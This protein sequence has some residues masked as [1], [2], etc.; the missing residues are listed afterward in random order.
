MET[1]H[2]AEF[3]EFLKEI[4]KVGDITQYRYGLAVK[5]LDPSKLSQEYINQYI[6]KKGND[7]VIRGA[8][9]SFFEMTGLHRMFD[10]PPKAT[11]RK[12]KR[13]IR[14][15]S[16]DDINKVR[17]YLY[18]DDFKEGLIFDLIYQGALRRAEVPP[19]RINSFKWLKFLD[20]TSKPC[21]LVVCGKGDKER[22]VLINSGTAEKIFN[23][24]HTK[25]QFSDMEMV[26]AFANSVSLL[27]MKDDKPF[28]N[29]MVWKVVNKGSTKS[30]GRN[31]RTH[32]LRHARA[33][34][35]VNMGVPIKDIQHYLG[36]TSIA[37]TEVYLHRSEK[38]SLA[39]IEKIQEINQ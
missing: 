24:Y 9:L 21:H 13:E 34:E 11:G 4:K 32:E 33:T 39:N 36:H 31:I 17:D 8:M 14:D 28:S 37:T 15:V 30:I 12:R 25:Y 18:K 26:T 35:L 2:L 10:L 19:I 7:A 27:F 22:T 3:R 5:D 1:Q 38:E 6:Q 23:F 16:I 20:D 29:W